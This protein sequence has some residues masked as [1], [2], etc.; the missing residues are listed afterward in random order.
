[1]E[2]LI[3]GFRAMSRESGVPERTLRTLAARG[4]IP[5]FPAA[6]F[7]RDSGHSSAMAGRFW[8]PR[9]NDLPFSRDIAVWNTVNAISFQVKSRF[10]RCAINPQTGLRPLSSTERI[11]KEKREKISL[12]LPF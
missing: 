4:L 1:M 9:G 6:Q 10:N 3:P 2:K 5:F 12:P 8:Q 11:Q 7:R